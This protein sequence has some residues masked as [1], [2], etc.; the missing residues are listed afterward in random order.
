MDEN[1]IEVLNIAGL[2][3]DDGEIVDNY[4]VIDLYDYDNFN[5]VY[6]K[7]EKNIECERDSDQTSLD[8]NTAHITYLYKDVL[9]ELIGLFDTDEYSINI[10]EEN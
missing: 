10:Y 1:K 8:E 7:L 6:N 3:P 9:V 4:F 2:D 5:N